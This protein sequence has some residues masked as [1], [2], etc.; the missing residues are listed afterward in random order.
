MGR[1]VQVRRCSERLNRRRS[2]VRRR[3]GSWSWALDCSGDTA[4]LDEYVTPYNA[5]IAAGTATCQAG[6][7]T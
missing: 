7:A 3:F 5:A 6:A 4:A 1:Q 2:Q